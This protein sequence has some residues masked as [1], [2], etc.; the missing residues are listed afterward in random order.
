MGGLVCGYLFWIDV[1]F[2]VGIVSWKVCG[3]LWVLVVLESSVV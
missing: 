3:G 2:L 1:L